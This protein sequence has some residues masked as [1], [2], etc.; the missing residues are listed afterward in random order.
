MRIVLQRQELRV[1]RFG[2]VV[3]DVKV[4]RIVRIVKRESIQWLSKLS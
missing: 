3:R 2:R 1:M 4:V